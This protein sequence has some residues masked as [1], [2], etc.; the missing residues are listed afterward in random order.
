[1]NEKEYQS[2]IKALLSRLYKE[3]EVQW[4]P[5]RGYGRK[6]YA[7][8][9]DVAVGPFAIDDR[10]E[11]QYTELLGQTRDFIDCLI[12]KHNQ[13]V[14]DVQERVS[15][16]SIA[17][18]NENPRCF[19]CIEVEDKGG[20]KH[21]LGDLINASALGRIGLLIAR[22][23][24]VLKIFLRQRVYLSYLKSVGK[25]TFKTDNALIIT[26]KQF[27]ECFD[28]TVNNLH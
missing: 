25:N 11:N 16:E 10:Y 14:E 19:L 26:E 24:K 1:M 3:V 12:G 17:H 2:K 8:K 4:L 28:R 18:F 20:R 13:N 6:I 9:V 27:N 22:S 23:E 15:F 7:P 5:F 21:C